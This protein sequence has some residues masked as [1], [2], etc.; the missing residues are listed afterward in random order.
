MIHPIL[1]DEESKIRSC[2][3][4]E[5]G[6]LAQSHDMAKRWSVYTFR[7]VLPEIKDCELQNWK[8]VKKGIKEYNTYE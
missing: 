7:C 8:K 5:C 4:K 3:C 1:M 2:L 6:Y